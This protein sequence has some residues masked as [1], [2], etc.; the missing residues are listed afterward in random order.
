MRPGEI[1]PDFT[2][3]DQD[4][5]PRT[6]SELLT[7]GPVVLFFYP[8]AMTG[9]CT[10]EACHFRDL[11]AEFAELGAQRV[12]ISGD[13]VSKQK[14]F[15]TQHTFDYPLLSDVDGTVSAMFGVKR[16]LIKMVKRHTFIIGSDRTVLDVIKS[17]LRFEVHADQALAAL[18]KHT[19]GS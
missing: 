11:G 4:G 8:A 16:R 14:Q 6:L 18:R 2:L 13:A 7:D 1:V 5:E 10:A 19:Q 17:E 15:A 12:G 9:G 3:P